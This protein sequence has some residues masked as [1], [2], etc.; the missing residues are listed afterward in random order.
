MRP[1]QTRLRSKAVCFPVPN[2]FNAPSSP[3]A[4]GRWKIQFCQAVNRPNIL[5][6]SVSG[7]AKRR[8]ASIPVRESG[9]KL[10][11]SSTQYRQE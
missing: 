2:S 3:T 8:L 9:E 4:L 11:R 7:P 5:V 6:S 1:D 10:R